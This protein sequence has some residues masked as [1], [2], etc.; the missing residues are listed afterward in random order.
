MSAAD[1][2]AQL[3]RI[4]PEAFRHGQ[5]L[6]VGITPKRQL[7][8]PV[9]ARAGCTIDVLEIHEPNIEA[10][11]AANRWGIRHFYLGDIVSFCPGRWWDTVIWWHGPEHVAEADV[12]RALR[13]CA[14][15]A[16]CRAIIGA[17]Y[18][19]CPNAAFGGNP[20]EEHHWDV[21]ELPFIQADWC[22]D[23]EPCPPGRTGRQE[24]HLIAWREAAHPVPAFYVGGIAPARPPATTTPATTTPPPAVTTPEPT[25]VV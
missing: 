18:G 7:L 1:W 13:N 24:T 12:G 21:H 6:Y 15:M 9:L 11:R 16:H 4:C 19:R 17:P 14:Q 22:V 20:Y 23:I 10:V 8:L 3:R 2:A 25:S 5:V